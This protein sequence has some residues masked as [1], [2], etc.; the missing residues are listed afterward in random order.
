MRRRRAIVFG[1]A[2]VLMAGAAT[3]VV[4]RDRDVSH[5]SSQSSGG[6]TT[7]SLQLAS[8][9]QRDLTTSEELK[10]NVSHGDQHQLKLSGGGTLTD[11]PAVG[12]VIQFGAPIVEVDGGP[13]ILMQG[14]RPVWRPLGAGVKGED[15]RQ[16]ETDLVAL[17]F[18]DPTKVIVDDTWT[19]QTTAAVKLMQKW[20][21]MPIDGR[22]DV[23]EIVFAPDVI[24]IAKLGGSLGDGAGEAGLEVGGLDQSVK[25]SVSSSKLQ[26]IKVGDAVVVQL[27]NDE[28]VDGTIGEIGD[29]VV[30]DDGT[31]TFPVVVNTGAIDVGDG[32][33]VTVDVSVVIAKDAIAVP[34]EAL[35]ALAEGGYAVEVPDTSS[36]T[37]TRLVPVD[38]GAFA[39]SWVQVTGAVAAGD[40][41]VV[42]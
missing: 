37:G 40:K 18:A 26:S 33:S 14:T 29:A 16:L 12:D 17:G 25:A 30:A 1:G 4:V 27:P 38:V 5:A 23:G 11:L 24:R 2:L 3:T 9:E 19:A 13:V 22:F 39:D 34:A 15:V 20:L 7:S 41:V 6:D 42:P 21:H 8:A 35:L 28:T 36:A 10:G 32:V 31:V